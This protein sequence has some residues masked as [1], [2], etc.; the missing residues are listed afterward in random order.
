MYRTLFAILGVFALALVLVALTFSATAEVEADFRF[1]NGT[2]PKSLDPGVMTGQPEG[3][4]ADALFEGL[5]YRDTK[6]LRPVPGAASS[7]TIS[8]DKKTYTFHMREGITWTDGTPLTA[9]D[10]AWTWRRLQEP[11]RGGEYPYILHMI[12][13]AE[14]YNTF[15]G[16]ATT[17][18][19]KLIPAVDAVI[20]SYPQG[21]EADAWQAVLQKHGAS[22][23]LKN[24]PAPLLQEALTHYEGVLDAARLASIRE[25]LVV[26]G[27]RRKR[28]FE[29]ADAH[30]GVDEGVFAKDDQTLVVQLRAPTPYFLEITAFYPT[31]PV[32]RHVAG[33]PGNEQDWFMPDKIVSNGPFRMESWRVNDK[34]RLVKNETYWD[35]ETIRLNVIDA[36][37]VENTT[38]ALNLYLTGAVDWLAGGYP[39]DLVDQLR[40]RPDFYSAPGMM[41]YYYRFNTTKWPLN[42]P[43]VRLALSLAIDRKLIV[44][45]VMRLGQIPARHVV[46]PGLAGYDPPP[47]ELGFDVK[48]ARALLAEAGFPDGEGWPGGKDAIGILYNTSEAHKKVAEVIADQLRRNLNLDVS[49]YNEEWQ[50][51]QASVLKLGYSIARAGWIGDYADPNTFLDMWVT[52][53]GNNQT[54]WSSPVYDRLI[55]AASNVE[56]LLRDSESLLAK[57]KEPDAARA[58]LAAMREA[59]SDEAKL[60]AGARLR[61]HLFREAEAILVQDGF[62]ICPIY[63]YVASGLVRPYVK[64]FYSKLEFPD[65]STADNLQ[66]IH[67]LRGMWIEHGST[68]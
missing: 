39:N 18:Q 58:L 9:H 22:E 54:G 27:E 16:N 40:E 4:I 10:F 6:T 28:L 30:F 8:D 67:P 35:A 60:A 20:E 14:I 12:E 19:E 11:T 56:E 63:F 34:I 29:H 61:M 42:D 66:D 64:G 52:N 36:Y 37:S 59:D 31:Y 25:A 43:R 21:V 33:V 1:I 7:W 44:E 17:I 47:S 5:T 57:L 62:P 23:A 24:V 2:E 46:P 55:Q 48:R 53:G 38:T 15:G 65:G 49:S 41:V 51:Y 45:E 50:A 68:R 32:P 13:G 3:R 26:E